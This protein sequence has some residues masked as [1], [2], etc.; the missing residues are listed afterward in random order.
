MRIIRELML[1]VSEVSETKNP[2][3]VA[4]N[5]MDAL[6]KNQITSKEFELLSGTLHINC[7]KYNISTENEIVSLF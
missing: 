5:M 3:A 7:S 6:N 1:Q 4:K 2:F